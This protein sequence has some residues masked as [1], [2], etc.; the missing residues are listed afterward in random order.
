G[1][2]GRVGDERGIAALGSD[3]LVV[4]TVAEGDRLGGVVRERTDVRIR[5]RE[6]R[7]PQDHDQL[8]LLRA[9]RAEQ[10]GLRRLLDVDGYADVL[11][12]RLE[13]GR[14]VRPRNAARRGTRRHEKLERDGGLPGLLQQRLGLVDI[15]LEG[16][17]F[18][19][20]GETGRDDAL[21]LLRAALEEILHDAVV[22]D[23]GAER[24]AH[25]DVIERLH[26]HVH[27][28]VDK[29]Q[30]VPGRGHDTRLALQGGDLL[31]TEISGDIRIALLE[32]E[33]L[34]RRL[35]HVLHEHAAERRL[36]TA[37]VVRIGFQLDLR[38]LGPVVDHKGPAAGRVVEQIARSR[39]AAG[40]FG[41]HVLRVDDAPD[42]ERENGEEALRARGLRKADDDRRGVARLDAR[43]LDLSDVGEQERRRLVE[44]EYALE[45]VHDVVR[46]DRVAARELRTRAQLERDVPLR[47]RILDIPA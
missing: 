14:E 17:R 1:A 18:V 42:G 40:L 43:V 29:L 32:R 34:V 41:L 3:R 21:D 44:L 9:V 20:A 4:P 37:G 16:C 24:L 38:V 36:R 47:P 15:G 2:L 8:T 11:P 46:G 28:D 39:V 31:R 35:R 23:R 6:V 30:A 22:I 13:L 33:L 27:A 19:V 25:V 10:V 5:V 45:R 26:G 7:S 12:V